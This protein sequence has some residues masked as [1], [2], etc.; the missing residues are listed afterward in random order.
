MKDIGKV[1]NKTRSYEKLQKKSKIGQE[2]HRQI[3][4]GLKET[5]ASIEVSVDLSSGNHI[6]KDAQL[7]NGDY[8][9]IKP[10]TPSGHKRAKNREK[11]MEKEG[12][13]TQTIYYDP[14]DPKYLPESPSYIG[15][16]KSNK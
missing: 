16:K 1:I 2:A 12:Y 7:P 6:R 9:I 5:G 4:K 11:L 10:D 13:N 3:E 8:V 15:P 14:L